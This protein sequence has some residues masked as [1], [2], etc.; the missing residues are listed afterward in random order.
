MSPSRAARPFVPWPF[1]F[2][3]F[4]TSA[5]LIVMTL[6]VGTPLAANAIPTPTPTIALST[7]TVSPYGW[8]GIDS[9]SGFGPNDAL[10]ITVDGTDVTGQFFNTITDSSG[11]ITTSL[12]SVQIPG[13][14]GGS[15][16]FHAL[17]VNDAT[18][19]LTASA[20]VQVVPAPRPTP[21]TIQRTISQM[22]AP[23]ISVIFSGFAP[24]DSTTFTMNSQTRAG[25]CG[26]TLTADST[27]SVTVNCEWDTAFSTSFAAFGPGQYVINGGNSTGTRYSDSASLTVTADAPVAPTPPVTPAPTV[28]A[29]PPVP[30]AP[31]VPVAGAAHFT[32]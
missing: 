16:G 28:P 27:G 4:L 7:A 2:T 14:N 9:V 11:S 1:R 15:I 17:I 29:A 5:G 8:V 24:G 10:T 25:Q 19:G 32:G 6:I 12:G 26:G 23:G 20:D 13:T 21:S 31:A 18:A 30:A 3:A 22:R